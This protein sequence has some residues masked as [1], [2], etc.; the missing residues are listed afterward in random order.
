[1]NY[2]EYLVTTKV[3]S[4]QVLDDWRWL[5]GS[6]LQLWHVT[7]AGDAIL[8]SPDD[9]SIHFLE[10]MAGKVARTACRLVC[11]SL[12][13]AAD[14]RAGMIVAIHGSLPDS[15]T[16]NDFRDRSRRPGRL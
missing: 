3:S 12:T 1:M 9:G 11:D 10:V 13:L 15:R 4:D 14:A 2:R 6:K 8:C 7:K 5:T 16:R